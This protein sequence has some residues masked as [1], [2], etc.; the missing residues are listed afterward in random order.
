M[1]RRRSGGYWAEEEPEGEKVHRCFQRNS[2]RQ[3]KDTPCGY[4]FQEW[5]TEWDHI[6]PWSKGGSSHSDNLMPA[7]RWCNRHLS[8]KRFWDVQAKRLYIQEKSY[9]ERPWLRTGDDPIPGAPPDP[10]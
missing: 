8:D 7:C 3:I 1:V 9:W 5:A 6:I 4:C 2:K 10:I